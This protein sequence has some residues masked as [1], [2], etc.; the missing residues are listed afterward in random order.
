MAEFTNQATLTFNGM[1]VNSNIVTGQIINTLSAAKTPI[2]AEYIMGDR[3]TYAISIVNSG[4]TAY[5]NLTVR[6]NLGAYE[7]IP[8]GAAESVNLYPLTYVKESAVY[9][10]NGVLQS[11]P[12]IAED[13]GIII[14]GI[15]IPANGSAVIIYQTIANEFAPVNTNGEIVNSGSISGDGVANPAVFT[16]TVEAADEAIL[17]I[18]KSLSPEQVSEN[19]QLTYTFDISNSGNIAADDGAEVQVTDTFNPKLNN[20]RVYLNGALLPASSYSYDEESGLFETTAGIITVPAA[21]ITQTPATGAWNITPGAAT[22][23][24]TGTI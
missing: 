13:N 19:G 8:E 15:N 2:N 20:I 12:A 4:N 22:L 17:A 9:F 6:D 21:A 3:I 5:N 10:I 14:S 24:V 18:V 1:T 11:A 23:E 7:F 16:A